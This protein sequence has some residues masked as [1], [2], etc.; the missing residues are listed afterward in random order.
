MYLYTYDKSTDFIIFKSEKKKKSFLCSY[1]PRVLLLTPSNLLYL[2][3][4]V[5]PTPLT[6]ILDLPLKTVVIVVSLILCSSFL[7]FQDK[8]SINITDSQIQT[9]SL[10]AYGSGTTIVSD[11]PLAPAVKLGPQ[12]SCQPVRRSFCL[13]NSGRRPQQIYW[14]TEGFAPHRTKKKPEYNPDD[15]RF[16]VTEQ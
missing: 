3:Y 1:Y 9:V 2:R 11:P 8:L 5:P 10:M 16:Q 14:T 6:K 13:T 4:K 12:F 7:R 15:M